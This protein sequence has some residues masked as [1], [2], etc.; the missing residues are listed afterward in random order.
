MAKDSLLDISGILSEY[1]KDIQK[2]TEEETI[3]IAKENVKTLKST[4]PKNVKN[5]SRKGQ[6]AKGWTYKKENGFGYIK[7]TIH[8]K[9]DYQL[10]HL[11]EK[12]H[13]TRNGSK[14]KA[15]EHIA[16][17]ETEIIREYPKRI[18]KVIENGGIK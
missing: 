12:G 6:Y 17:V 13:L 8:N 10:T 4:S 14:T 9:T 1:S 7:C 3:S 2:G 5:S 16:P 11:L 15:I 18:E